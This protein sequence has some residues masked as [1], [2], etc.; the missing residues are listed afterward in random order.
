[1]TRTLPL[2]EAK[3]KLSELVSGIVDRSDEIVITRNGKPAAVLVSVDEFESWRETCEIMSDKEFMK[4]IRQG[5]A[6]SKKAKKYRSLDE[7]FG[8]KK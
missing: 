3:I 6:A 4:E 5:I 1:M 8:T 7:L 2:S